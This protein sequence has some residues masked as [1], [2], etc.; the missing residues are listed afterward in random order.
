[1]ENEKVVELHIPAG[2]WEDF[3]YDCFRAFASHSHLEFGPEEAEEALLRIVQR[4]MR[5][6]SVVLKVGGETFS[7]DYRRG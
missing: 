2:V 4:Y 3:A 1:M 7:G 6:P 5:S